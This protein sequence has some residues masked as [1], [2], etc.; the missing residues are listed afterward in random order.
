MWVVWGALLGACSSPPPPAPIPYNLQDIVHDIQLQPDVAVAC[1]EPCP[2]RPNSVGKCEGGACSYTCLAS[3]LDCDGIPDNGCETNSALSA[4]HCG[5]CGHACPVAANSFAQCVQSV[6]TS[7]CDEGWSDCSPGADGCETATASNPDHCGNCA[8]VCI[9][10][11]HGA[12]ICDG[13]TCGVTCEAGFANCN[14]AASDGCEIAITG[15][16]AH[17]GA[18][19]ITCKDA[20][21]V[22]GACICASTTSKAT[23]VPLDMYILVDQSKSM[24]EDTGTPNV[25]K[26]QAV[27]QALN[28]FV[29]DANSAGIGVAVQYFGLPAPGTKSSSCNPADYAK[30]EVAMAA[31]PGNGPMIAA[32]VAAHTPTGMT[33]TAPALQGAIDYAK[34][35]AA[36]HPGHTVIAVLATDGQP[37]ECAPTDVPSIAAL[38]AAGVAGAPKVLTFVI[39]VGTSLANL[40][41]IAVGGGSKQAFVVDQGGNV[42]QQFAAAL[43]AI[44][45]QAIGCVYAIPQPGSG[46]VLDLGKLNVQVTANGGQTLLIYGASEAMCDP[47]NGGWH[48]DSAASPS[49]IVL[50]AASCSLVSADPQAKVD[51]LLGCARAEAQ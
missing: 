9:A 30:P 29:T 4:S 13:G 42:V 17:C 34:S 23:L 39:G 38:A 18:C 10:G 28:A 45:G 5:A 1:T 49:K 22:K 33:P 44:Q 11:P 41:V 51:V 3:F 24:N 16:P 36:S 32:S 50:C 40:D 25:N 47:V 14:G 12:A 26:W 48:F 27:A 20:P 43:K 7:T 31:L 6:C 21:C 19:G 8:T 2:E 37:T 46:Q 35:Y 15:D